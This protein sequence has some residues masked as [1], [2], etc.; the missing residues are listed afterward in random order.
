MGGYTTI[1]IYCD[2]PSH[3]EKR[4]L[5]ERFAKMGPATGRIRL[6]ISG[7]GVRN[8]DGARQRTTPISL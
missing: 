7:S 1:E 2:D 3:A 6:L 5:I 4:W 8:P